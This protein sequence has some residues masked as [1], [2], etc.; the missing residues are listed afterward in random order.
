MTQLYANEN[1]PLPVVVELRQFGHD[2]LTTHESGRAGIAL[3]DEEV[4]AF[5]VAEQRVLLTINRKHFIR[6]HHQHPTHTGIIV[7]TFDLDSVALAQR[8]HTA[9]EAQP[10]IRGQL[11]RVNRP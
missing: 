3:P 1:F 4:L 2:V 6:L 11:I 7:S 8:I 10:D 5:A 9:L